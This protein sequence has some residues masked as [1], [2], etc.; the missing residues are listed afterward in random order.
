M[1]TSF[2]EE[3]ILFDGFRC[4]RLADAVALELA[5]SLKM[6]RQNHKKKLEDK[7][8]NR[9]FRAKCVEEGRWLSNMKLLE[10]VI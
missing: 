5:L 10:R 7:R 3:Y 6:M 8:R 2:F 1:V 9:D 4:W